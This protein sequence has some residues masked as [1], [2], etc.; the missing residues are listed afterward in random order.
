MAEPHVYVRMRRCASCSRRSLG[1]DGVADSPGGLK[2]TK[3]G[4]RQ[5][6]TRRGRRA[7]HG[8]QTIEMGGEGYL[9]T[10]L[11]MEHELAGVVRLLIEGVGDAAVVLGVG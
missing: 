10:P 3:E 1:D 2:K 9:V 11:F 8:Y 6:P 4:G 7:K 5:L